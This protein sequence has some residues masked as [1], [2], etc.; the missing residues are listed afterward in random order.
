MVA[1][2]ADLMA[3]RALDA[4]DINRREIVLEKYRQGEPTGAQ[5]TDDESGSLATAVQ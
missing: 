2:P 3:I 5:R 4:S 1:D